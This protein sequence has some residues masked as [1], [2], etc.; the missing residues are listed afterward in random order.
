MV[1]ADRDAAIQGRPQSCPRDSLDPRGLPRVAAAV[2]AL[3]QV[4]LNLVISVGEVPPRTG[5][6]AARGWRGSRPQRGLVLFGAP[7]RTSAS[8]WNALGPVTIEAR[9]DLDEL[10]SALVRVLA[11]DES[12][13]KAVA[14]SARS[15]RSVPMRVDKRPK[16]TRRPAASP[17]PDD[18]GVRVLCVDDHAVLVEGLKAQFATDGRIGIV[19]RLGSAEGLLD[20]VARRSPDV[21]LL[22]IEM[23]GPDS[24]ETADR[25]R[26]MHPGVRVIFLSAHIRDGYVSAAFKCG[27]WGYFAKSDNLEDISAGV[28]EVARNLA[29]TFVLG[30]KVK[31]R[32]RPP[33][34]AS[35]PIRGI[36]RASDETPSVPKT[37]LDALS[38]REV[39]VLRLIGKGLSRTQIATELSR[40]AKTIDGHQERI[41]KKLGVES[42]NELMRLAIREGFA[43]V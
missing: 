36:P 40:S 9:D 30:P 41:M 6:R 24:F 33:T 14:K 27:A 22:D 23:P 43:E 12:W 38:T 25:L 15:T 35:C 37:R 34:A 32:C 29:G 8:K 17:G 42:R 11:A 5:E 10:R 13:S 1:D 18:V 39:E 28:M 31:E 21:V 4:V 7:V 19:G 16:S 26:H 2:Q 3:T 20:E